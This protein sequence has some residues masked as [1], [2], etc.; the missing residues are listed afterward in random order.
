MKKIILLI[1]LLIPNILYA[2]KLHY[3]QLM[4]LIYD[5]GVCYNTHLFDAE[6]RITQ[7][8]ITKKYRIETKDKKGTWYKY[9]E[10]GYS[11]KDAKDLIRLLNEYKETNRDAFLKCLEIEKAWKPIKEYK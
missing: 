7:N 8:T 5:S 9:W 4:D 1:L 3:K 10:S 2:E 11:L 6:F